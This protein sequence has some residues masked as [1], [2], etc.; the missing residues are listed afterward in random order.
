MSGLRTDERLHP[1]QPWRKFVLSFLDDQLVKSSEGP[2]EVTRTTRRLRTRARRAGTQESLG[3]PKAAR[4]PERSV[5]AWAS[6]RRLRHGRADAMGTRV[7]GVAMAP[8][9]RAGAT[10]ATL[11][12]RAAGPPGGRGW[13]GLD[14]RS[15]SSAMI[16][17][18]LGGF[19]ALPRHCG[20]APPPRYSRIVKSRIMFP[21]VPVR[22]VWATGERTRERGASR[23]STEHGDQ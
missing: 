2:P 11:S 23:V 1:A 22:T 4:G 16:M 12:A 17:A 7:G 15:A 14:G 21:Y 10:T 19:R 3:A 5:G 6:H 8:P 18:P 9:A 13:I 20:S